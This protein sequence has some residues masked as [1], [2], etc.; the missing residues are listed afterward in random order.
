MAMAEL[1]TID[2]TFSRE[3]VRNILSLGKGVDID[4]F[5]TGL[6]TFDDLYEEL[7]EQEVKLYLN[8]GT[9]QIVRFALNVK[10][11]IRTPHECFYETKRVYC[12]GNPAKRTEIKARQKWSISETR[13]RT[14]TPLDAVKRG[15]R[16]ELGR[17]ELIDTAFFNQLSWFEDLAPDR[18]SRVYRGLISRAVTTYFTLD[19][20]DKIFSHGRIVKDH[21]THIY[22]RWF[23]REAYD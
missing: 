19:L 5:D 6:K 14:E 20:N 13:K 7:Q 18:P 10:L 22:I 21:D 16:E 4:T 8:R 23:P 9:H 11:L 17:W 2:H 15:F 12:P 3:D 1:L